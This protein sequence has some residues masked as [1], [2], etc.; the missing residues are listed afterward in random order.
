VN[1]S[2]LKLLD[3]YVYIWQ[4]FFILFICFGLGMIVMG[5]SVQYSEQE[6]RD[7]ELDTESVSS[8]VQYSSTAQLGTAVFSSGDELVASPIYIQEVHPN[9]EVSQQIDV[10]RETDYE[11]EVRVE[12]TGTKDGFE[13][14]SRTDTIATFN[15][16]TTDEASHSSDIN[17]DSV[18][19]NAL[20][21]RDTFRNRGTIEVQVIT[22]TDYEN[23]EYSATT[24]VTNDIVF[25]DDTYS[26]LPPQDTSSK[27]RQVE[28]IKT[29]E[30]DI[31]L[32]IYRVGGVLAVLST[33]FLVAWRISDRN[34]ILNDYLLE[35]YEEWISPI[36]GIEIGDIENV[37]E[38]TT[39]D[40]MINV[41][42]DHGKRVLW[43]SETK[44]FIII[45]GQLMVVYGVEEDMLKTVRGRKPPDRDV[46]P[47]DNI[48]EKYKEGSSD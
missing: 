25:S 1:T 10:D 8:S 35:K 19:E 17:M 33:L 44:N 37:V 30:D 43:D 20:N 22:V 15:S 9:L 38:V 6:K 4:A 12:Y 5:A 21:I 29:V 26:V 13:F 28:T 48:T 24:R 31:Y 36:D 42:A 34:R 18:R 45:D 23:S 40:E 11:T 27:A 16:T 32:T 39:A 7:V 41:A 3:R 47:H 46:E 2:L 14:W